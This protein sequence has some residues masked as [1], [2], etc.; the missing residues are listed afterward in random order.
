[1]TKTEL[2]AVLA[3]K[4]GMRKQDVADVVAAMTGTVMEAM[5]RG[6]LVRIIGFGTWKVARRAERTGRHPR[7]GEPL[8][9]P[10]RRVPVFRPG[11]KLKAAAWIKV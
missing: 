3:K 2:I 4:T 10:A 5:E 8:I 11:S 9:I 6:E 7:T 1:M